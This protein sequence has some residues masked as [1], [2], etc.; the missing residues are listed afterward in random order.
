MRTAE[1]P[2]CHKKVID[3][4]RVQRSIWNIIMIDLVIKRFGKKIRL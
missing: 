1:A 3:V 2:P 4:Y